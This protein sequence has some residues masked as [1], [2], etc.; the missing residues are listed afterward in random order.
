MHRERLDAMEF[1]AEVPVV[2]D[3]GVDWAGNIWVQ[4]SAL[5]HD[6]PGPIDLLGPNGGYTGTIPGAEMPD[7]FGPDGL[8]AWIHRDEFDIPHIRVARL[9]R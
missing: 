3:L 6:P 2:S 9:T 7:A 1:M 8:V 4:R 5:P